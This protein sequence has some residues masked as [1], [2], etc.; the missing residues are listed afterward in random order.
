M[1]VPRRAT[2]PRPVL[3]PRPAPSPGA[4]RCPL[5][6]PRPRPPRQLRPVLVA[7]VEPVPPPAQTRR[8]SQAPPHRRH[9]RRLSP[10]PSGLFHLF[11]PAAPPQAPPTSPSPSV[12]PLSGS[13]LGPRPV[14]PTP[15]LRPRGGRG[16]PPVPMGARGCQR[17]KSHYSHPNC[18][19]VSQRLRGRAKGKPVSQLQSVL[20]PDNVC[21]ALECC[22]R[23]L[24]LPS[25]LSSLPGLLLGMAS[26]VASLLQ[27]T[28]VAKDSPSFLS[29][30]IHDPL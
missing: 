30:D 3:R 4:A 19:L 28:L 11:R 21:D 27:R 25:V 29:T 7:Q 23:P 16:L 26:V 18:P 2:P 24:A 17:A 6:R 15:P 10:A 20:N 8:S 9:S 1:R 22:R 14:L 12:P 13:A 5:P